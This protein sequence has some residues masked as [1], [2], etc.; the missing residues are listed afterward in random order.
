M[1]VPQMI[2]H[3]NDTQNSWLTNHSKSVGDLQKNKTNF[4]NYVNEVNSGYGKRMGSWN[5]TFRDSLLVIIPSTLESEIEFVL[6]REGK[7]T[8]PRSY[9]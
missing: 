2:Q 8:M 4:N 1:V 5:V 7:P 9:I 6:N 3:E